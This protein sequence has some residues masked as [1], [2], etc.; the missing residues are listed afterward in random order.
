MRGFPFRFLCFAAGLV[1]LAAWSLGENSTQRTPG[2][3]TTLFASDNAFAG[4]MFD[5][6][7]AKDID[8]L[9]VDINSVEAGQ[10]AEVDVYFRLGTC[11]GFEN[12]SAGWTLLGSGS[13][14]IAGLDLPTYIDLTGN[15]VVF[16][17]G[18]TYGIYVDLKNYGYTPMVRLRYTSGSPTKYSNQDLSL[19][20]HCGN[21]TPA[22]QG[23]TYSDRIWN[24]TIY[25]DTKVDSLTAGPGSLSAAVGGKVDFQLDA[26][27]THQY[28]P[29]MLLGSVTGTSPG[30]FLPDNAVLPLN[31][32]TF[33]LLSIQLA[34]TAVFLNTASQLDVGGQSGAGFDTLGPLP[35]MMVGT[36]MSFAFALP[37]KWGMSWFTSNAVI[38]A[39]V[40]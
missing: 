11:V 28:R 35:S 27:A 37:R 8:I 14:T 13:G 19:T 15:G 2:S 16:K 26:G 20:T 40:P 33:T 32:D 3:L 34:N 23:G 6:K 17:A 4:N 31:W 12:S 18:K 10:T 7:P 24:G 29:Y 5:I 25:Y 36:E 1:L 38:V 21:G 39:V 9:A 22:F 30:T